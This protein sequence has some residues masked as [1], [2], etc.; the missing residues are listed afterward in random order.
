MDE[1]ER[2]M[3][4]N[5]PAALVGRQAMQRVYDGSPKSPTG[6]EQ[7]SLISKWNPVNLRQDCLIN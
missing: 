1:R 6:I 5:I 4:A 7:A 2:D 3:D